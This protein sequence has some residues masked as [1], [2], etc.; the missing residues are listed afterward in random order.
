MRLV[1]I[2]IPHVIIILIRWSPF[3]SSC[4]I[5]HD[6]GD[7]QLLKRIMRIHFLLLL[8]LLVKIMVGAHATD[9]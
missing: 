5:L 6:L 7:G 8:L 1:E 3:S 9:S 4:L 2:K